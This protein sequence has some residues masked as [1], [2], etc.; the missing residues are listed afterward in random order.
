MASALS[1]F[2]FGFD[3][4]DESQ[5]RDISSIA[6]QLRIISGV[7]HNR[8]C[9][10]IDRGSPMKCSLGTLSRVLI[11]QTRSPI[12]HR[13]LYT[14]PLHAHVHIYI[15]RCR[16]RA[17]VRA[18][19]S[20]QDESVWQQLRELLGHTGADPGHWNFSPEWWGTQG[21]GWGRSEGQTVFAKSSVS[22]N[23][24]VSKIK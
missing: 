23:C 5:S 14:W 12:P 13:H 18:L 17:G 8:A 9:R 10:G 21:G 20:T 19:T 11:H 22:H 3:T 2:D 4:A 24:M 6:N 1:C 7:N 15:A 16:V